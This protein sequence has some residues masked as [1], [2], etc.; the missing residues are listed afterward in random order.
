MSNDR[1]LR[2]RRARG[3]FILLRTL[4]FRDDA[5]RGALALLQRRYTFRT[6]VLKVLRQ[7]PRLAHLARS[8]PKNFLTFL[9]SFEE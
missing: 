9:K 6:F 7:S 2:T 4:G 5:P 3:G 1:V 8:N